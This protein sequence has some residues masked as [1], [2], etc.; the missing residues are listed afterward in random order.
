M[1]N[2]KF[3]LRENDW[4]NGALVYQV[5]VDRFNPSSHLE[6]KKGLY[7]YPKTLNDWHSLP[8]PGTFL[9]E[10]RYWSHELDFWGGDL[11]SLNERL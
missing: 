9:E 7:L 11:N 8:K 2:N 1:N 10:H 6:S 4:R 5:L 3:K